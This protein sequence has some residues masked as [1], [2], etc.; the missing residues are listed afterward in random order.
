MSRT[1]PAGLQTHLDGETT[2]TATL[3]KITRTDAKVFLFTDHDADITFGGNLYRAAVGYERTEISSNELLDVDNLDIIGILNEKTIDESDLRGGRYDYAEVRISMV[4]FKDPDGDGEVSLKNGF[5][6]EVIFDEYSG[7]FSTEMR[8]I[9]Q[10]YH[11]KIIELY[12]RRCRFNV[13]DDR[14]TLPILPNLI[15]PSTAYVIGDELRVREIVAD[16]VSIHTPGVVDDDDDSQFAAVGTTG[17]DA[18]AADTNKTKN[19][20]A[21]F[22]FQ[23]VGGPSQNPSNS[24]ISWPDAT[25]HTIGIEPFT[26]EMGV[27]FDAIDLVTAG[28]GPA[29]A[30]KFTTT[31]NQRSWLI[32]VSEAPPNTAPGF[33]FNAYDG[34]SLL[35]FL[36]VPLEMHTPVINR[37]YHYAVVRDEKYMLRLFVDGKCLANANFPFDIFD[38]AAL[39]RLGMLDNVAGANRHFEGSIED[40]RI[41]VGDA[42]YID[43][44]I[45]PGALASTF[46]D[47]LNI[48]E[49]HND[50]HYVVTTAGTTGGGVGIDNFPTVIDAT[51]A[52]P[53]TTLDVDDNNTISRSVG[54]F[55]DDG[56][57]VHMVYRSTGFTD[58]AN[59]G[60]FQIAAVTATTMDV[61]VSSLVAES[62]T[63]DEVLAHVAVNNGVEF[64]V[65]KALRVA[66]EVLEVI[67]PSKFIIGPPTNGGLLI[68]PIFIENAGFETGDLSAWTLTLGAVEIHTAITGEVRSG[69]FSCQMPD[70][71]TG[72]NPSNMEQTLI[73]TKH[74]TAIDLGTAAIT[75]NWWQWGSG[76]S[77]GSITVNYDFLD[78]SDVSISTS[79]GTNKQVT[80]GV[81]QLQ[82]QTDTIPALTR[83]IVVEFTGQNGTAEPFVDDISISTTLVDPDFPDD[84]V[85]YGTLTFDSGLN[86]GLSMEV[87]N[88]T[89]GDKT[90][91]LYLEMPYTVTVGDKIGVHIGCNGEL[92]RCIAL[93]NILNHGGFPFIPGDDEFLRVPD[94]PY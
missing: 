79:S 86:S 47:T 30:S 43:D 10:V 37:W 64:S 46:D 44:F 57:E 20:A 23:P 18:A 70:N 71:W 83:K 32:A 3:W 26:I 59:N 78:A 28:N 45:P 94:S 19:L 93:G 52:T 69:T 22:R 11:Q 21:N 80:A 76:G 41:V 54:S 68:D 90:L 92:S 85:T 25:Q 51:V 88:Y 38:G 39:P 61:T 7:S 49:D 65:N 74:A 77:A 5:F 13:G 48:T 17:S 75:T 6:G 56:W 60:D 33:G 50:T 24:F 81:F 31:G 53:A 14:C 82:A 72:A 8:G 58:A 40:F 89:A 4:N 73:F 12:G 9:S 42:V 1:I 87:K 63:G 91:T 34:T 16:M 62:G 84:E 27:N 55:I 67:S 66:G 2:H 36:R 35:G 29:L 15:K